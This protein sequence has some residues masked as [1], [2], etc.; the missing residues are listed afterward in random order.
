[1]R[2]W[3]TAAV[4]LTGCSGDE[5]HECDQGTPTCESLLTIK[6]PDPRVD[7]TLHV[8]DDIG[9][10]LTIDCPQSDTGALD[11][12]D[13]E[14]WCGA[15]TL[16]ITT[17]LPLGHELEIQL[18]EGQPETFTP[19]YSRGGDFCGNECDQGTVQL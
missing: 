1:M 13:Y 4:A 10:D 16:T 2:W 19:T 11:F 9:M 17:N 5:P 18:E 7:F 3:W 15:G 8:S 14:A 6:L 12:G